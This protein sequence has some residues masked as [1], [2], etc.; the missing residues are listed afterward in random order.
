MGATATG[1]PVS[2]RRRA[3]LRDVAALAGVSFKTVS[4][5]VNGEAGVSHD[6]ELR[7][8]AA[9]ERLNYRP[10]HGA[11]VLRRQDGRSMT[12]GLLVEDVANPFF[13]AIQR[14]AETVAVEHGYTVLT[15]S[16]L[17]SAQRERELVD[18]FAARQVDG[19]IV[20]PTPTSELA[21]AWLEGMSLVYLDRTPSGQRGDAEGRQELTADA[22]LADN[23]VG[24]RRGV[25]HL[26]EAGHRRIAFL[27]DLQRV[28]TAVYRYQGYVEAH[29]GC[30]VPLDPWLTRRDLHS[31]ALIEAA[32]AELLAGDNP[33]SAIFAGQ[34]LITIG[35]IRVLRA[36]GREH[37]VALVGFDD[38][39]LAD[40]LIPPVT[41][42]AQDPDRL[43]RLATER[44]LARIHGDTSPPQLY[45]VPTT[46]I[47]RGSGEIPP[48]LGRTP[49]PR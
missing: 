44:L 34:N 12:M 11:S 46:L 13:A 1:D 28:Q 35:A 16:V 49:P 32:T 8:R 29:A 41:V 27:G 33:P 31:G 19:L 14:G 47:V 25:Q 9:A 7:V 10:H 40:L 18:A 30:G 24:A 3:T 4:R 45:V 23:R 48:R 37:D 43:G 6:L 22:V 17:D 5:V 26:I 42:V 2:R 20:V 15:G 21:P 39:L 38:F 36:L